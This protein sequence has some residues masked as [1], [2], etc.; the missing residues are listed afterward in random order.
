M[1]LWN[2]NELEFQKIVNF[3]DATF[4]NKDLPKFVTKEWTEVYDQ[5]EKNYNPN[6]ETRIKTSVL[7]SN[8]CDFS[9]AY[10][11]VTGNITVVKK[12]FTAADFER[13]NN[14]NLNATNTNNANNITF[15][16]KN[17]FLKIMLHLLIAFQKLM[18]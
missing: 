11:A 8:L 2:G 1:T 12:I 9:D 14:T 16:E 4:D 13:S 3:L 7:R 10:I 5:S 17:C 15:G 6:K 18:V